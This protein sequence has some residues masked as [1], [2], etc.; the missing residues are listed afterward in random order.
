MML[1]R[2]LARRPVDYG[3]DHRNAALTNVLE[4]AIRNPAC[5]GDA[6]ASAGR[7]IERCLE[8]A[9]R[10]RS[11]AELIEH[12]IRCQLLKV[13]EALA[14]AELDRQLRVEKR[15][16]DGARYAL[17]AK[18]LCVLA[19]L[20]RHRRRRIPEAAP[21]ASSTA[22]AR[23]GELWRLKRRGWRALQ[24]HLHRSGLDWRVGIAAQLD[25]P[26]PT[27]R[28][29]SRNST[30]RQRAILGSGGPSFQSLNSP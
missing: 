2:A 5:I 30:R 3:L 20:W 7:K 28:A 18:N 16:W 23:L 6:E 29:A 21:Y 19:A 25:R 4:F 9:R 12:R 13:K 1:L 11:Q 26:H 15:L 17:L 24:E 8:K 14:W 27:L 10:G 22:A